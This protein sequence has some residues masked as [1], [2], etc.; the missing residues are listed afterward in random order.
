MDYI[1]DHPSCVLGKRFVVCWTGKSICI[2]MLGTNSEIFNQYET[3]YRMN[4]PKI[5][6]YTY[7]LQTAKK[8]AVVDDIDNEPNHARDVLKK[9]IQIIMNQEDIMYYTGVIAAC[10]LVIAA[11][12]LVAKRGV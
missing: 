5:R 10:S 12:V 1:G 9:D 4:A 3:I 8:S 6:S 7:D 11:F 2:L